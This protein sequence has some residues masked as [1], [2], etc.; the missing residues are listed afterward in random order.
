MKDERGR[1]WALYSRERDKAADAAEYIGCGESNICA[2]CSGKTK[3]C[4]GFVWKYME[5]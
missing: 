1:L 2:C 3:T 5:Q 4:Y